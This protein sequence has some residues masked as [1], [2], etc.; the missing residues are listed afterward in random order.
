VVSADHQRWLT[1]AYGLA[2]TLGSA[3]CR[4]QVT[5]AMREYGIPVPRSRRRRPDFSPT[6]LSVIELISKGWTNRQIAR[7]VGRSEKTVE[8]HLTQLFSR[9]GCCSRLELA[10][11]SLEGRL[12]G[13]SPDRPAILPEG[14]R[15]L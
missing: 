7:H 13:T 6:E 3:Y 10:T 14:D 2:A 8:R 12:T 11:A 4:S 5:A 1:E 15:P 9:T